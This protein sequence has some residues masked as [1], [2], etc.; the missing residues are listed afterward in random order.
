MKEKRVPFI[1]SIA[2]AAFIGLSACG[3]N[4]EAIN[5]PLPSKP[6]ISRTISPDSTSLQWMSELAVYSNKEIPQYLVKQIATDM[7]NSNN[8][9]SLVASGRLILD[10]YDN[11]KEVF[12]LLPFPETDNPFPMH[13]QFS[14]KLG[15]DRAFM[16]IS[17]TDIAQEITMS[18]KTNGKVLR[19]MGAKEKSMTLDIYLNSYLI[20][21]NASQWSYKLLLAK[22]TSHL[23]YLRTQMDDVWQKVTEKYN[24]PGGVEA[25]PVLLTTAYSFGDPR[26][27]IPSLGAH[28]DRAKEL[29]D[30]AGYWHIN[31]DILRLNRQGKLTS[32]DRGAL[33]ANIALAELS[34]AKGLVIS[35]NKGI[36]SWKEG[37]VP[38]ADDWIRVADEVLKTG[39]R[40]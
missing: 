27:T 1:P 14:D 21:I 10:Q 31:L 19:F 18:D 33:D 34:V 5:T 20:N 38:F 4:Q 29:L 30:Y 36:F 25:K 17:E 15:K 8:Y 11:P 12:N 28:F 23:L 22:E 6:G 24:I 35:D 13:F 37:V 2:A 39:S 32:P 16:Q 7:A 40:R 3:S 26:L 9:P